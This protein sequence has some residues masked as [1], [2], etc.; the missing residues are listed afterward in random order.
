LAAALDGTAIAMDSQADPQVCGRQVG[1][2]LVGPFD[3]TNALSCKEFVQT[4]FKVFLWLIQPI[5]IKV[6]QV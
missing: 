6:I 3:Q 2:G 4:C 5:K 1:S